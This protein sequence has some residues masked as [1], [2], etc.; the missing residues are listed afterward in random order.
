MFVTAIIA[1]GGRGLRFGG[2]R[3]KQLVAIDGR[4]LL[5]RSVDAFLAHP[6]VNEVVVALPPD[7]A[8]N[9]PAYLRS[10]AKPL[11]LVAGGVR[12]Q[13]SVS[14]ALQAVASASEVILIHDAARPFVSG[15]LIGRTI[16]AAAA[17]GAAIAA[18]EV[19]DTVK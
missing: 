9:P 12:R 8:E 3:P 17:H 1:A 5:E 18:I 16:D 19:N 7:I 6:L 15:E 2:P 10:A 11:R 13:D 14:N 4:S